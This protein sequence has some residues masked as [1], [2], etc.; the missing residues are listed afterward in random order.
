MVVEGRLLAAAGEGAAEAIRRLKRRG[1]WTEPAFAEHFALPGDA[2][3]TLLDMA[4]WSHAAL[5]AAAADGKRLP[6]EGRFCA[7]VDGGKASRRDLPP[8]PKKAEASGVGGGS[9]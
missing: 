4:D 7:I 9:S 8:E 1:I 3:D 6:R 2:C 5:A